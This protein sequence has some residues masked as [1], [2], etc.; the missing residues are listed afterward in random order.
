MSTHRP[1]EARDPTAWKLADV[2]AS[3][4]LPRARAFC[5]AVAA[6]HY[7]NFPVV[8]L[9]VPRR[10]RQDFANVYAFARWSDDLAD[11][12]RDAEEASARLAAWRRGLEACFRGCPEHPVYVAL[13]E[14]VERAR[15]PIE[16][17]R[18]LL[19]AFEQDQ[20]TTRYATRASLVDYCRRSA[21]PVGRIVLALDGCRDPESMLLSDSICTGLQLV[22]F[23]QDL[24]RDRLAGRVYAPAEDLDRHGVS[25]EDLA[26][27]VASAGVRDLTRAL[28]GWA[29]ECFDAGSGL[30]TRAPRSLR[31]AISAFLGGGR[32][33]A[34]AIERQGW[35]TLSR[36]PVVGP[37]TKT[38][39]LA[40]VA[41]DRLRSMRRTW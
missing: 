5:R 39:L 22:N 31:P 13:A 6:R 11:E 12:S 14:T 4:D 17:F 33:I 41:A 36:R 26:A 1:A 35:D 2:P 19:D 40:G 27:P 8:S 20:C 37:W 10:L 15:L 34:D 9:L 28:V 29:R 18:D 21:D 16:P 7:E 38:K 3:G 24:R 23:G 30:T 25:P 32:A